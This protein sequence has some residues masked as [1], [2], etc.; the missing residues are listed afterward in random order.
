[1][2]NPLKDL[3]QCKKGLSAQL[4]KKFSR[5]GK[6]EKM[7]QKNPKVLDYTQNPIV[8]VNIEEAR[9]QFKRDNTVDGIKL[10]SEAAERSSKEV[11]FGKELRID[12]KKINK[13]VK[14]FTNKSIDKSLE[15][16]YSYLVDNDYLQMNLSK[17]EENKRLISELKEFKKLYFEKK[18]IQRLL[19]QQER[20]PE[21]YLPHSLVGQEDINNSQRYLAY[22][23]ST[24]NLKNQRIQNMIEGGSKENRK[25]S[26]LISSGLLDTTKN[27]KSIIATSTELLIQDMKK[28]PEQFNKNQQSQYEEVVIDQQDNQQDQQEQ[29]N[30]QENNE[31]TS[32]DNLIIHYNDQG[33]QSNVQV[34]GNQNDKQQIVEK[35][36]EKIAQ[37]GF[38]I[39][40]D[41]LNFVNF[42]T[43]AL[44]FDEFV[45]STPDEKMKTLSKIQVLDSLRS[46]ENYLFDKYRN[47]DI[48]LRVKGQLEFKHLTEKENLNYIKYYIKKPSELFLMIQNMPEQSVMPSIVSQSVS[49]IASFRFESKENYLAVI[50][51]YN[52][53]ALLRRCV[54]SC[55]QMS[56]QEFVDMV[57]SLGKI[58][59]DEHG[60]VYEKLFNKLMEVTTE[61]L[62]QRIAQIPLKDISFLSRGYLKLHHLAL[63]QEMNTKL[64]NQIQ[65]R[66]ENREGE[67]LTIFA[68]Q[69]L[70]LYMSFLNTKQSQY[71]ILNYLLPLLQKD[72]IITQLDD[73]SL[74]E[75]SSSLACICTSNGKEIQGYLDLITP[76]IKKISK[77]L[78]TDT[79][80]DLMIVASASN[81]QGKELFQELKKRT[82][83][84]FREQKQCSEISISKILVSFAQ[85][86]VVKS[87]QN[88]VDYKES[89]N[90]NL[91]DN[92]LLFSFFPTLVFH[93]QSP[94]YIFY[95]KLSK[96]IYQVKDK[97]SQKWISMSL[98]GI[99]SAQYKNVEFIDECVSKILQEQENLDE[100]IKQNP[101]SNTNLNE[102]AMTL[103]CY[104]NMKRSNEWSRKMI[105]RI[106]NLF[107][108]N[109]FKKAT[110]IAWAQ[111]FNT[112]S[113]T[114]QENELDEVEQQFAEVVYFDKIQP[115]IG[116]FTQNM[117]ISLLFSLSRLKVDKEILV[118][119]AQLV[120]FNKLSNFQ[121]Y[122]LNIAL[123]LGN[124]KNLENIPDISTSSAQPRIKEIELYMRD[125]LASK[126]DFY[127][128]QRFNYKQVV[129]QVKQILVDITNNK[130]IEEKDQKL[131]LENFFDD[132]LNLMIDFYLPKQKKAIF[133]YTYDN[134]LM[135]EHTDVNSISD[136]S[137]SGLFQAK[138][139]IL[140]ENGISVS[141]I[142]THEFNKIGLDSSIESEKLLKK[143]YVENLLNKQ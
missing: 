39:T 16:S 57:W 55:S 141:Y 92:L 137:L 46:Y 110:P 125:I 69:G 72:E 89:S 139:K 97:M 105:E 48:S 37:M 66:L 52:Y 124:L 56:D 123:Q 17:I 101:T 24:K 3:A 9:T 99:A 129:N 102:L 58:H 40:L 100:N 14:K 30:N 117:I 36:G 28:N 87:L 47:N 71:I 78:K 13:E 130:S 68:I 111:F 128:N 108:Q 122:I 107:M 88:H 65:A 35:Y 143:K 6:H 132:N 77:K 32:A 19:K 45:N 94:Q 20:K 18:E 61:Q 33:A 53:R 119:L 8:K 26:L 135:Q 5:L 133:V 113:N 126:L 54:N 29:N 81:Y 83:F 42:D 23:E 22:Q 90:T 11:K 63:N 50:S 85:F 114:N 112:L 79:I 96:E 82:I 136:N 70:M 7:I 73:M 142:F 116:Y 49:K 1:M 115:H 120:Q 74:S 60:I 80:S 34:M 106:R 140:N 4:K 131:V 38:D 91:T 25:L 44:F 134:C 64:L 121:L 93:Q 127:G 104:S 109:K 59:K 43:L 51:N 12:K 41:E 118:E 2:I 67:Q 95:N 75:I 15:D 76:Q 62:N 103:F 21:N 98:F 10:L 27:I 138:E 84:N 86:D 31:V